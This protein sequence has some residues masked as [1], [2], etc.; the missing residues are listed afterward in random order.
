MIYKF[1]SFTDNQITI[2]KKNKIIKFYEIQISVSGCKDAYGRVRCEYYAH[3]GWCERY[4]KIK[5]N[6]HDTC[7]CNVK[8]TKAPTRPQNCQQSPHGCCWDNKT[9]KRD[10]SGSSCPGLLAFIYF[11]FC[12][13]V[14]YSL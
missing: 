1:I 4:T 2:K 13:V 6:C 5:K 9:V 12:F 3:I 10:S 7:V 11:L 8:A 14:G